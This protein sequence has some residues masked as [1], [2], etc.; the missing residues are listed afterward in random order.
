M[1]IAVEP[2]GFAYYHFH[3]N[4][5]NE[6]IAGGLHLAGRLVVVVGGA[7]AATGALV[8]VV[9]LAVAC[10]STSFLV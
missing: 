2:P 3:L 1:K 7:G 4:S 5:C 10:L 6:I 8:A 9:A